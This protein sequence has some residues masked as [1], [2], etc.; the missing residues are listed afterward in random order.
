MGRTRASDWFVVQTCTFFLFSCLLPFVAHAKSKRDPVVFWHSIEYPEHKKIIDDVV[1][2]FNE[3][4]STLRVEVAAVPG[5]MI[6][7][8]TN[9]SKL[10]NAVAS[11]TGPDVYRLDR[12]TVAERASL[13]LLEDLTPYGADIAS[14]KEEFL[15]YVVQESSFRGKVFALPDNIDARALFYRKDLL[16]K[17]GVDIEEFD[18]SRGPMSLERFRTLVQKVKVVNAAGELERVGIVP[19]TDQGFFH[20]TWGLAHGGLFVDSTGCEVTPEDPGVEAG[21]RYGINLLRD[22][23]GLA[24][25]NSLTK[26]VASSGELI[27][28]HPF[29]TGKAVFS[30]NGPWMLKL[31][32]EKLKPEQWGVTYIPSDKNRKF[33]WS[34]G[35]SYV[36]PKGAKNPAGGYAFIKYLTSAETQKQIVKGMGIMPPRKKVLALDLGVSKEMKFFLDLLPYSAS[37]PVLPVSAMYWK[38]LQAVQENVF[39]TPNYSDDMLLQDLA[40]VKNKVGTRLR[41]YCK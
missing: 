10:M 34:G 30:I 2:R 9:I 18:P 15:D 23:G 41:R 27:N 20:Y 13:K 4:Q 8:V 21:F 38:E 31:F 7:D 39:K 22:M 1:K 24:K 29:A 36:V 32:Q 5:E 19:G 12:F 40:A 17:A 26:R 3:Q 35:W 11:G 37:R 28:N 16:K 25:Y 33:S 6:R 14:L